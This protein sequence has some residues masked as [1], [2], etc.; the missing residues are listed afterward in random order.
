MTTRIYFTS[1]GS[2]NFEAPAYAMTGITTGTIHQQDCERV[3][4]AIA[5]KSG[6]EVCGRVR[7]DGYS[8]SHGGAYYR[9]FQFTIGTPVSGGGWSPVAEVSFKIH[10]AI[11]LDE[12]GEA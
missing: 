4:Q 5:R 1:W 9:Q 8:K 6:A 10:R 3:A 2:G 12:G 7:P 11:Y